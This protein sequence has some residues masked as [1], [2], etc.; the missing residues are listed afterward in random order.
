LAGLAARTLILVNSRQP[1]SV[2]LGEFYA[3]QRGIPRANLIALP[4]PEEETITWRA[5]VDQVWQPLQDRLFVHNWLEGVAGDSLDAYGR[6]R[7]S[8]IGHRI[9]YL[10]VCR[11]VPL[12]IDHDPLLLAPA[13]AARLP[14]PFR[15]N[16]AAV[17]S[18]LSLLAAGAYDIDSLVPNPLFNRERPLDLNSELI[19]RVARLDGPTFADARRLVASALAGEQLGLA[20]RYYID[21]KGPHADG[22]HW[23]EAARRQ[24]DELGFDGDI[25]ST[26]A[27][28]GPAARF[29]APGFYFGWYAGG[30]NGPFARDGFEFPPGAI[31]LHI[32]SASAATLRSARAGWAGPLVARGVAATVG[33]VFEPYLQFTHRPDILLRRLAGGAPLGDAAYAALPALSW[34][35]ILLGDPLYRPFAIPLE[36]QVREPGR[37][38]PLLSAYVTIRASRLLERS[39]RADDARTLLGREF[40]R[41]PNLPLALALAELELRQ[42][43]S[44][45]AISTLEFM[46]GLPGHRLEDWPLARRGAQ[47]LVERGARA[48]ALTIYSA[49]AASPAPGREARLMLLN[50]ARQLAEAAGDPAR[51]LE[52][53]RLASE[54]AAEP[55]GGRR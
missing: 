21:L 3:G 33:N 55:R 44:V 45:A 13:R 2:A 48:T 23:L 30:L 10:V 43:D 47:L 18:E 8:I 7:V 41:A 20:G 17:D 36:E 27:T 26:S 38:P 35:A 5:F 39:D 6:R 46:R 15:T 54:T 52:F 24:L 11:G 32:H 49:L 40:R 4:L 12:R 1:D 9:A 19:V 29:D 31:A 14:E 53:A 22:D 42:G 25:E 37:F 16:Q 34:Q 50:E 28:F 51:A